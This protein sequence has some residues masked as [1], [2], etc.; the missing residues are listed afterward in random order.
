[1]EMT[2]YTCFLFCFYRFPGHM[3][4]IQVS[5]YAIQVNNTI[6]LWITLQGSAFFKHLNIVIYIR[7]MTNG[8]LIIHVCIGTH[9]WVQ[10]SAKGLELEY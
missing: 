9:D 5:E 7:E 1:M 8:H 6:F 10:F 4:R 3:R 2:L